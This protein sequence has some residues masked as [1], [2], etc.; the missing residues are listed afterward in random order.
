MRL[1]GIMDFSSNNTLVVRK[2]L[3]LFKITDSDRG[4]FLIRMF[5]SS[6]LV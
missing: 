6:T 2:N 1:D 4:I 3:L 5:A